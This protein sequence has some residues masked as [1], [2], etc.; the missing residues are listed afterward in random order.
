MNTSFA[1]ENIKKLGRKICY[2]RV[3][4]V[5]FKSEIIRTNEVFIKTKSKIHIDGEP[6]EL[7]ENFF[8]NINKKK[9][10]IHL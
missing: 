2:N 1:K 8:V 10:K 5:V 7:N 3:K 6:I 4:D 9:I